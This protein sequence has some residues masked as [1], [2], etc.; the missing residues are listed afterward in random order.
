MVT[1]PEN[2]RNKPGTADPQR[3]TVSLPKDLFWRFQEAV[4]RR[5][6]PTSNEAYAQAIRSW[7]QQPSSTDGAIPDDFT[8]NAEVILESVG[9]LENPY[10]KTVAAWRI[11]RTRRQITGIQSRRLD[12]D[13]WS[14]DVYLTRILSELIREMGP[15][16]EYCTITTLSFWEHLDEDAV[17]AD[18]PF[19]AAQEEAVLNGMRI[20][21]I[22]LLN[23]DLKDP[24]AVR[25][26]QRHQQFAAEVS[27]S[28][29]GKVRVGY[30]R[31]NEG[32]ALL[33][34]F[35]HFALIRRWSAFSSD[36]KSTDSDGGCMVVEP[37]YNAA[38]R[39]TSLRFLFS[40][41]PGN[42]DPDTKFYIDRFLRA[43]SS[44]ADLSELQFEH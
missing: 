44:S 26:L 40:D 41:G 22:F 8:H 11:R 39:I 35:G 23:D 24:R 33:S 32:K 18:H 38:G 2:E 9:E 12:L 16:N 5:R 29:P 15:D 20:H 6:V 31:S 19:L 7:L 17:T 30:V 13:A 4:A 1:Q 25:E 42:R 36:V 34:A 10:Q 43:A 37:N 27:K 3:T 14:A 21:R 28:A